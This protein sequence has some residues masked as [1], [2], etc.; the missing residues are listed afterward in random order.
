MALTLRS[1]APLAAVLAAALVDGAH[2]SFYFVASL[3]AWQFYAGAPATQANLFN[4]LP[5]NFPTQEI[6]GSI[7]ADLGLYLSSSAPLVADCFVPNGTWWINA[8]AAGASIELAFNTPQTAIYLNSGALLPSGDFLLGGS[9]KSFYS[10]S[11][12]IASTATS[13]NGIISTVPIDRVVVTV[14]NT[15]NRVY[16]GSAIYFVPAP[17]A[18]GLLAL[19]PA[20]GGR[21]RRATS[22]PNR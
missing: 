15:A 7:F 14:N 17:G 9:T 19:A 4:Y 12:L 22:T 11:T 10:G 5:Y 16:I 1:I 3:S 21:R 20:L 13:T 6:S 8:G 2:G 18:L